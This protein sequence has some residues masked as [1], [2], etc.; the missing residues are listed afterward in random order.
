MAMLSLAILLSRGMCSA[1][2][3]TLHITSNTTPHTPA[4][5]GSLRNSWIRRL[6]PPQDHSLPMLAC[7]VRRRRGAQHN[8]AHCPTPAADRRYPSLKVQQ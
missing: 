3:T 4:A 2:Q 5:V 8:V 7:L 6:S 1:A